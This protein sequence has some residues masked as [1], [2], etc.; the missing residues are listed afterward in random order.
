M[1][2]KQNSRKRKARKQTK[3]KDICDIW[4][5]KEALQGRMKGCRVISSILSAFYKAGQGLVEGTDDG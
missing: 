3:V 1:E 2:K 4:S 5:G